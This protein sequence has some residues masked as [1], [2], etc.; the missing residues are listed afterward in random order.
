MK[1]FYWAPWIGNVG[2]IKAVINSADILKN[3]QK[4][5][6]KQIIDAVGEWKVMKKG[7]DI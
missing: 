1:I 4:I 3:T 5:I 7:I 2:T 6:F